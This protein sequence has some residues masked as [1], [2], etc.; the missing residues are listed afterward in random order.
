MV[1]SV[2]VYAN[3]GNPTETFMQSPTSIRRLVIGVSGA[4]GIQYAVTALKLLRN[5]NVE[6]HLVVSKAGHLTR[7]HETDVSREEL[8][9][10]ASVNY[11]IADVGAALSSGS[12]ATMGM[13]ILPCSMR[14]L[15]AIATGMSDS[16]LTRAAD[17]TLKERRRL[18]LM[19]RE[20]PLHLI[21]LRNMQTVTDAGA[22][23]FPPVPAFYTRPTS[24]DDIVTHSV[25]RAL[26]LF[27][28]DAKPIPR[29]GETIKIGQRE[30][31]MA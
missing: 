22:V 1:R 13:I 9:A 7:A 24:I 31:A 10:L 8:E 11:G 17:V 12:F 2:R 25:V 19:T 14:T 4:S 18:V 28:L 20:T 3:F 5:L 6:T 23:I 26:D 30:G 16:L 29:W 21:H 15:A 27:G